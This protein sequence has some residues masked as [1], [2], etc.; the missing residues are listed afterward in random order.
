MEH[1]NTA[2][3]IHQLFGLGLQIMTVDNGTAN[4]F[5]LITATRIFFSLMHIKISFHVNL[6]IY[7]CDVK[8]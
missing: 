4:V 7:R 8:C 3:T 2:Y 5:R 1:T 6:L